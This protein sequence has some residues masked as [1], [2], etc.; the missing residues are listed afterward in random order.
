MCLYSDNKVTGILGNL[1]QLIIIKM[2]KITIN[3][4]KKMEMKIGR[5]LDVWE[6]FG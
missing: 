3:W 2:T 4:Q 5:F 1:C 6:R